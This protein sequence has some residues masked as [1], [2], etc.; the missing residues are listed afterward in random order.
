MHTKTALDPFT[1]NVCMLATN[2]TIPSNYISTTK[3]SYPQKKYE[4]LPNFKEQNMNT[5]IGFK[6]EGDNPKINVN[7]NPSLKTPTNQTH[8]RK[9]TL[10]GKHNLTSKSQLSLRKNKEMML[11]TTYGSIAGKEKGISKPEVPPD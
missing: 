10:L 9:P 4:K 5:H 7:P 6:E 2:I 11:E 8:T 3:S 1:S